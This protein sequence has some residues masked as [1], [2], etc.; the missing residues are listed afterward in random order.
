MEVEGFAVENGNLK[1]YL[2][3]IILIELISSVILLL[4]H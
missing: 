1:E 3:A 2:K 4:L